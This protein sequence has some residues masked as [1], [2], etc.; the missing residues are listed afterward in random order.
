VFVADLDKLADDLA[1]V[2]EDGDVVLTL[3]AGNIGA[4]AQALPPALRT[5]KVVGQ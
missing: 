1:P 4:V 2:L 5:L 3:G